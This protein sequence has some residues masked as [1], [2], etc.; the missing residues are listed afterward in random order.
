[1][2]NYGIRPINRSCGSYGPGHLMHWIQ[3]KKS[4]EEG[5]PIIKVKVVAV[6]DDGRV[7]I[8]GD[9]LKLMLWHHHPDQLRSA[10]CFDGRPTTVQ[11]I[12]MTP[13]TTVT[14]VTK[15]SGATEERTSTALGIPSSE[16]A[17][18]S[19]ALWKRTFSEERDRRAGEGAN[20]Q[21]RGQV[22]RQMRKELQ[23]AIEAATYGENK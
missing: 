13:P 16:L 11:R 15:V 8:E 1:M 5:Q 20:A 14:S 19:A 7:E 4:H 2:S 3:G 21:K 18:W 17:D 9:D 12:Q 22:T 6:H 10:L 23:A